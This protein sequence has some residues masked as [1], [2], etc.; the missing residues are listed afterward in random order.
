MKK[1]PL[2]SILIF[3]V[4]GLTSFTT[5]E[6]Y[7]LIIKV[8]NLRNNTGTVQFT[9]YNKEGSIPDEKFKNYYKMTVGAIS[10]NASTITFSNLPKGIYAV[11]ILHDENKDGKIDKGWI[12]PIEGIGFSNM[13]KIG[14]GNKPNFSKTCFKLDSDKTVKVNIVYM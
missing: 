11:N 12:L 5:E 4:L 3:F 9:L 6:S 13:N 2:L 10:Q 1:T 14:L 7:S 8:S